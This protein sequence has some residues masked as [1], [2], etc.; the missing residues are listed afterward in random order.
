MAN[1][2]IT[3]ARIELVGA[4]SHTDSHGR[5]V[6]GVPFDTSD[7]R[8][9]AHY[10]K[11]RP[12]FMITALATEST[13]PPRSDSVKPAEKVEEVKPAETPKPERSKPLAWT[14][15]SNREELA[16]ACRSRDIAATANDTRLDLIALLQDF[17]KPAKAEPESKQSEPEQPK[18]EETSNG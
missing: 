5:I 7:R 17:D 10:S 15:K 3:R 2:I 8:K 6:K 4:A 13:A 14:I 1:E 18:Q 9:I 16:A 11:K 12:L